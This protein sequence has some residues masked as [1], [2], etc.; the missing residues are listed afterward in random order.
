LSARLARDSDANS[1]CLLGVGKMLQPC[2]EAAALLAADGIEATVW[3][4]RVVTPIDP[5]MLANA[6]EHQLVVSVEDGIRQ[7]GAGTGFRTALDDMDAPCRVK[8]LGVP[9]SYIP[10]GP[11]GDILHELGLDAEGIAGT[12]RASL[13]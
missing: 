10:H 4:P 13:S 8:V 9:V 5:A 12:V 7:G 6:A 11:A 2:L 3:D 1:V